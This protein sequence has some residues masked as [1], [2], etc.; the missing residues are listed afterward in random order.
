M[1]G[2]AR[3]NP[4]FGLSNYGDSL[5]DNFFENFIEN[6]R[7][8]SAPALSMPSVDIFSDNENTMTVR[9]E[10]PGYDRDDIQM[11]VNGGVLEVTGQRTEKEESENKKRSY[12]VRE[13]SSSFARRVAL[14]D[15]TDVDHITS[16]LDR[17]VLTV[18]IPVER[19]EAKRIEISQ[20]KGKKE[21]L[22]ATA[23]AET[24]T[25]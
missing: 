22:N 5:F 16:E 17:G 23:E 25:K 21:R 19:P 13:S 24:K 20:P 9:M 12:T 6:F 3:R 2:L 18:T 4:S 7:F 14:P 8:P 1:L 10:V 11:T 15:G